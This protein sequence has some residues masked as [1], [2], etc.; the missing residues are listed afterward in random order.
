MASAEQTPVQSDRGSYAFTFIISR[1]VVMFDDVDSVYLQHVHLYAK[2]GRVL[3]GFSTGNVV[4]NTLARPNENV[5]GCCS[6][7]PIK[8][9][10]SWMREV[11]G[12]SCGVN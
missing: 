10:T 7:S 6:P 3:P 1:V 5:L 12:F 11:N 8:R 4:P 2:F 9:K